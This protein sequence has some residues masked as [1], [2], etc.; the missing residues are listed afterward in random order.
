MPITLH[1]GVAPCLCPAADVWYQHTHDLFP[2]FFSQ[3]HWPLLND[4]WLQVRDEWRFDC[5]HYGRCKY[6]DPWGMRNPVFIGKPLLLSTLMCLDL[7]W[8]YGSDDSAEKKPGSDT[9]FIFGCQE[10][11]VGHVMW[12][13][14]VMSES[15]EIL[16]SM[17]HLLEGAQ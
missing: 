8:S 15:L 7:S 4:C 6:W 1:Q 9:M 11:E 5:G 3:D 14:H 16:V 2:Y 13:C 12:S 17:L 10:H